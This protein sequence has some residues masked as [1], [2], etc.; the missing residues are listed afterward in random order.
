M[1]K[2][3]RSASYLELNVAKHDGFEVS[4][5]RSPSIRGLEK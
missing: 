4:S 1:T 5:I 2:I 3:F